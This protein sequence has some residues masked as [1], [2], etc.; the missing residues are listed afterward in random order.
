MRIPSFPHC[1]IKLCRRRSRPNPPSLLVQADQLSVPQ[2]RP[3][4]DV[5]ARIEG[6]VPVK[7]PTF[8]N[9]KPRT[10]EHH[11][12]AFLE[13]H[14]L[15]IQGILAKIPEDCQATRREFFVVLK[16]LEECERSM[17]LCPVET[18]CDEQN[19]TSTEARIDRVLEAADKL[20]QGVKS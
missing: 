4:K 14:R 3:F 20:I 10:K 12:V 1:S 7:P 2:L 5:V 6:Q 16:D 18:V 19:A 15:K 13:S 17:A 9:L 8:T 11:T